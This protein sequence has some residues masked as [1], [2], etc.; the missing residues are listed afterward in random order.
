MRKLGKKYGVTRRKGR[1]I[2]PPEAIAPAALAIGDVIEDLE[3][4]ERSLFRVCAEE[5]RRQDANFAGHELDVL[6]SAWH[7]LK[8]LIGMLRA[9][10]PWGDK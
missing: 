1:T 5:R 6:F 2:L 10:D 9:R 8:G 3:I 4:A 7:S